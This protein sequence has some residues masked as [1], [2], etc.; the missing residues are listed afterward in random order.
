MDQSSPYC[1]CG[2]RSIEHLQK[3]DLINSSI[4]IPFPFSFCK[5]C[6]GN[7]GKNNNRDGELFEEHDFKVD[8]IRLIEEAYKE[9]NKTGLQQFK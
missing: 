5:G 9:S 2:H 1:I 6:F 7:C 8:N 4:P 3:G